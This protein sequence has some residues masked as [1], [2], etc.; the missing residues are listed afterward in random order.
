MGRLVGIARRD[1]KRAAMQIL[2]H[3]EISIAGGV[4]NDFRGKSGERQVTVISARAWREACEELGRDL[5]WT[6]RRANLLV[7]NID[8]PAAAGG[9]LAIGSVRL[10]INLETRPC[11]RMDEQCEGLKAAL[12]PD[13]RGG[14]CCS[15]LQGGTVSIG[16]PVRSQN[17]S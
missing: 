3:A 4:A 1:K 7:D 6:V 10:K 9:L 17:G 12:E 15:V 2:D 8:L 11:S 16:D 5:P 13:W 14:L